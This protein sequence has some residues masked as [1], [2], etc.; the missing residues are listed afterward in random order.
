MWSH[1]KHFMPEEFR[2][3]DLLRPGTIERLDSL[4]GLYGRPLIVSSSYREPEHNAAVDGAKDSAHMPGPDGYY[5]AVDLTTP[6]NAMP[7]WDRFMIVKL[8]LQL[9]FQRIGIYERHI[10]LDLEKRLPAPALWLA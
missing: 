3:P 1:V 8:A 6:A 5:S 7:S 9:G 4:R 2:R 10:H